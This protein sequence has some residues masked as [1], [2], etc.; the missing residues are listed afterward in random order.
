MNHYVPIQG[1]WAWRDDPVSLRRLY[2]TARRR[3]RSITGPDWWQ[4]GSNL[5]RTLSSVDLTILHPE[6]PFVWNVGIDGV[7]LIG[8][9]LRSWMAAGWNLYQYMMH[10]AFEDKNFLISSHGFQVWCFYQW[11]GG[12]TRNLVTVGSPIRED[13]LTK[14]GIGIF[15]KLEAWSAIVD[16]GF[17]RTKEMGELF[18]GRWGHVAQPSRMQLIR[19]PKIHH[20]DILYEKA[21]LWVDGCYYW[22]LK[23]DHPPLNDQPVYQRR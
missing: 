3:V 11:Y 8:N 15:A 1:T 18:D 9:K 13:V 2:K 20:T 19:I 23:N 17:D 22:L 7:P 10:E 21:H 12:E 14:A 4:R 16:S 6:N 5:D